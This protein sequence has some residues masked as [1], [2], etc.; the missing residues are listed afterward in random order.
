MARVFNFSAGPAALPEEVLKQAADEMLD[1]HGSGQSVM[2]M[3]HRGKEFMGIAAQAEADL[4]E[5]MAIPANYKVLFLQGG[6]SLQFAMIPINLLRGK[7]GAD[8]VH[9]GEWAKKA[10]KEAKMFCNVN[11]VASS[12]GQELHLR[13]GPGRLEAEQGCGLRALHRQRDHRRRRVP[14]DA[15]DRRRAAGLRHVLQHPVAADRCLQ[16]RPD[17]RRRAEEHR[18]GRPDH[19]HRPRRPDRQGAC[20]RRRPCST[21]RPTPTTTRCTTRRRPMRIYIAGL[22]FQWLKRMAASRRWSRRTS[23][24]PSC[25]TTTS[26]PPSSTATRCATADRSRMNVP[27]TLKDAA[28][29]RGVPQGGQGQGA[30]CS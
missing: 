30:W 9:T 28:S 5:L 21:T 3:S 1:W 12:R 24:R 11:V 8:Y 14:L 2:E 4:R 25:F 27:F 26:T 22:V 17:L 7:A 16:V 13:A 29:R 10:I 15:R 6:A 23:R 18:P 20:R 19:R